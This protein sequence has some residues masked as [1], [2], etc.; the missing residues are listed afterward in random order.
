MTNAPL[1]RLTHA[2]VCYRRKRGFIRRGSKEFWALKDV[3]LELHE[4]ET[5]GVVG[6]NG[7]GKSTLLRLLSNIIHPDRGEMV[8]QNVR[9]TMLSLQAGFDPFLSG[10]QNIILSGLLLGMSRREVLDRVDSIIALSEIEEFIDQPVQTYSSGMKARLGFSTAY[11]V[12]PDILLIDEVLGVG[13]ASFQQKSFSLL[14]EKIASRQT[15]VIVS[16]NEASVREL[17]DRLVWIEEGVSRLEGDPKEV[18][19]HYREAILER[20][21]E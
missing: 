12:D 11:N 16:H 6:R 3:N 21:G 10:R 5:L 8:Q 4:G 20:Q 14:K 18:L 2:G 15:V 1:I 13:D 17:C 19:A 9:S 7:A